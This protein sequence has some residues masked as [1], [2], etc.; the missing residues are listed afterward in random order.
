MK[1]VYLITQTHPQRGIV[2]VFGPG[3]YFPGWPLRNVDPGRCYKSEKTALNYA[4]KCSRG[5]SRFDV[6]QVPAEV[7]TA[8]A[9]AQPTQRGITRQ[10]IMEYAA[11][12]GNRSAWSLLLMAGPDGFAGDYDSYNSLLAELKA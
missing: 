11:K 6:I 7:L 9:T 1:P 3:N 8:T 12:H 2:C 4:A 5:Y 10:Q